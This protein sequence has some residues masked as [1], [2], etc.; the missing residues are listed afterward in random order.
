[1]NLATRLFLPFAALSALAAPAFAQ[2]L[3]IPTDSVPAI[4][5]AKQS[6]WKENYDDY[7]NLVIFADDGAGA[8]LLRLIT[9]GPGEPMPTNEEIANVILG[10]AGAKPFTKREPSSFAGGPAEAFH[11]TMQVNGG[12]VIRL[13]LLVRKLDGSRLAI[14]VTMIP[15]TATPDQR[16]RVEAQLGAARIATR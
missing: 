3:R 1:M 13:R 11:S 9:G 14:G 7:G 12:P 4:E 16:A 5:V 15:D 8:V 6:G 2:S 10:A